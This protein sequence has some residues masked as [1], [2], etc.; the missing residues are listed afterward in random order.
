MSPI[1][2]A[3]ASAPGRNSNRMFGLRLSHGY[4]RHHHRSRHLP[5][6]LSHPTSLSTSHLFHARCKIFAQRLNLQ[7]QINK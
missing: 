6:L 4:L 7:T 3:M 1:S 5:H 2:I